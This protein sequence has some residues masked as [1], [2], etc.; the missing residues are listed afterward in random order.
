MRRLEYP[1]E[2]ANHSLRAQGA[3]S[4]F[5]A[6]VPERAI[7]QR[8]GHCSIEGLGIYERGT[9]EQEIAV[10]KLLTGESKRYEDCLEKNCLK[11]VDVNISSA[12]AGT[13][14]TS[15]ASK[16]AMPSDAAK[17][18]T[19]YN[20]CNVNIYSTPTAPP[21]YPP[22]PPT[23]YWP[24]AP[25]FIPPYLPMPSDYRDDLYP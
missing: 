1:E 5:D 17:Q 19:Q 8:T 24:A 4:L 12:V 9:D 7:Q 3:T 15:P 25:S 21:C 22:C 20:N 2:K 10:F 6:G 23:T 14:G 16:T 13:S 11:E 18:V